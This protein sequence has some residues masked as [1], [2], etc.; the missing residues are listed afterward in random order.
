MSAKGRYCQEIGD[1]RESASE[2][3]VAVWQSGDKT[4]A[5]GVWVIGL[6]RRFRGG[7]ALFPEA[8]YAYR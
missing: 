4:Q 8:W 5:V 3:V 1:L 7:L 6:L 2:V